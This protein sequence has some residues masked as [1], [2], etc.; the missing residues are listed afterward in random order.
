MKLILS[1]LILVIISGCSSK[2]INVN[3]VDSI[4][5]SV[6][7]NKEKAVNTYYFMDVNNKV[8]GKESFTSK[9]DVSYSYLDHE[10]QSYLKMGPGG[11]YELS[12]D[13]MKVKQIDK[14][15]V[16]VIRSNNQERY[17]Y[18]NNGYQDVGYDGQICSNT[19]LQIG[20]AVEDFHVVNDYQYVKTM[21]ANVKGSTLTIYKDNEMIEKIIIEEGSSN[22]YEVHNQ[23]LLV[24]ESMIYVLK[25]D[26]ITIIPH[27]LTTFGYGIEIISSEDTI[28]LYDRPMSKLYAVENDFSIQ[29]IENIEELHFSYSSNIPFQLEK[30]ELIGVLD[31]K[32]NEVIV[33]VI[34]I[35]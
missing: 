30:E 22:F 5:V 4:V 35:K 33:D 6:I 12:L 31:L 10:F 24:S 25:D 13:S 20:E 7:Y 28:Y 21:E 2:K 11:V 19:C 14:R 23:V 32:N 27:E 8:L 18:V 9:G 3:E 26:Q 15:N 1:V 16:N 34:K 29:F 17:Y